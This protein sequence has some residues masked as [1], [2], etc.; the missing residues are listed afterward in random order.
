MAGSDEYKRDVLRATDVV[1]LVEHYVALRPVG[2]GYVALCP[3]HQE[4]TPSFHVSPDRQTWHCFGKCGRGGN[5]IDFLM[6]IEGLD[7]KTA[8]E[9]LAERANVRRPASAGREPGETASMDTRSR[10]LEIHSLAQ[11][12]FRRALIESREGER[13]RRYVE[14]RGVSAESSER[15]GLGYA[16]RGG[17]WL[18]RF[19]SRR[20]FCADEVA[21][22]GLAR[23]REEG[24]KGAY[25]AFRG[26]L[27]F[28]IHDG[29]GRV[30][31][32][33]GR[34]LFDDPRKYL[35]S[36][37]TPIFRKRE[38]LY[39]LNLAK[40]AIRARGE[41]AV[42]EG[43]TDVIL[44][45]Q[46]GFPWFVAT[47]GTALSSEHAVALRR[48]AGKVV[49]FFDTDE[50]G[51]AANERGLQEFASSVFAG[52]RPFEELRVALLPE[53]LDPADAIA[54]GGAEAI[55]SALGSAR[56]LVEYLVEPVLKGSVE[57]RA[58]SLE[59]AVRV[60]AS[61]EAEGYRE[62][63]LA[64]LAHR[65]HVSE[66]TVREMAS[67]VRREEVQRAQR[68]GAPRDAGARIALVGPRVP[69]ASA[70]A[71][72]AAGCGPGAPG[73][74]AAGAAVDRLERWAIECLIAVPSLIEEARAKLPL[75]RFEDERAREVAEAL[76]E[77][78]PVAEIESEPGR[79]LASEIAESIDEGK[80]YA[81]DWEGV[82]ERWEC[83]E[84]RRVAEA[85]AVSGCTDEA[86][87]A[88]YE[89]NRRVK[90]RRSP[91]KAGVPRDDAARW[92]EA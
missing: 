40:E 38:T 76:Y 59:R 3:F 67:R 30:V 61:F 43:Y 17:Q 57:A 13:A 44:A 29:S 8:L 79:R 35:N 51:R 15:F 10:L 73:G 7:F 83:R 19:L 62:L 66:A 75:E 52:G 77:G 56:S 11:E 9:R 69:A 37:E 14:K 42:V 16:P 63:Q 48:L 32:F 81:A 21:R 88:L 89:S 18:L 58:S 54:S 86:L 80:D 84:K 27:M 5:A 28:P 72:T 71:T 24:G 36:P 33:G 49:V 46:A 12:F 78:R 4:K 47:L 65:L 64:E 85:A 60:L 87:R 68:A 91:S 45:H 34:T 39:G 50:A 25:D 82:L 92:G 6:L 2:R 1:R 22:A 74:P 31:G 41:V 23:V 55:R 26:R 70:E 90:A 53:G 20:G